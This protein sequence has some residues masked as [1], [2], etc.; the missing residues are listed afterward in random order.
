LAYAA[1]GFALLGW[2]SPVFGAEC[3]EGKT[4][5][6]ING[7]RSGSQIDLFSRV[8]ARHLGGHVAGKPGVVVK[9]LPDARGRK[10][11]K[12]VFSRGT[13]G[14]SVIFFTSWRWLGQLP[15]RAGPKFTTKDFTLIGGYRSAGR[16]QFMRIDALPGGLKN[17][18]NILKAKGLKLGGTRSGSSSDILARL[19]LD[20]LGVKYRYVAGYKSARFVIPALMDGE[21]NIFASSASMYRQLVEPT[22]VRT[23]HVM[24]LWQWPVRGG[25]GGGLPSFSD[26]HRLVHGI[27]PAGRK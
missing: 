24:G 26:F 6:L 3:F 22:V 8:L 2:V 1:L 20:L 23:G 10:A 7:L 18:A 13:R 12:F 25:E 14:G 21:V 11:Q 4:V 15:G 27:R 17:G 19:S 5:T 16:V 9:N